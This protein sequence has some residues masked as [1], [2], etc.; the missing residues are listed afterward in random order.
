MKKK[1]QKKKT[2]VRFAEN[3]LFEEERHNNIVAKNV[4]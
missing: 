2:N 4:I 1:E 3:L